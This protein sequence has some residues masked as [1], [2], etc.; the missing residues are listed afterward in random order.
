M[1]KYEIP[2][3]NAKPPKKQKVHS[4]ADELLYI[5]TIGKHHEESRKLSRLEILKKYFDASLTRTKWDDRNKFEILSALQKA[6]YEEGK[7]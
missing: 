7:K 4:T 5:K 1:Y 3:L 2:Q 6:I